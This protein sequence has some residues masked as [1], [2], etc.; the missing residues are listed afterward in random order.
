MNVY[1]L[2]SGM[3]I[4]HVAAHDEDHAR[5]QGQD[6]Q[7]FP[8]LHFLPFNV[9]KIEVEGFTITATSNMPE[10]GDTEATVPRRRGPKAQ[11]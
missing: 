9:K 4:Y 11:G 10:T 5:E 6:P 8:D 1:E 2:R 3:L 7:R